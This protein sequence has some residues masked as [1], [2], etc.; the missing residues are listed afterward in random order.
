MVEVTGCR[1]KAVRHVS[2]RV[3]A[4]KLAENHTDK[5]APCIVALAMFVCPGLLDDLL[6]FS[7]GRSD[8]I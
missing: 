1:F 8:I 3:T 6:D 5:L 7:L 4:G 2:Y